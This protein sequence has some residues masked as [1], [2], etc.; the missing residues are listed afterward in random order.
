VRDTYHY[1]PQ[2]LLDAPDCPPLALHVWGYFL[3]LNQT[4]GSSGF[5]PS[6]LTRQD[7]Q[8]WEIDEGVSLDRWE[9]NAIMKLDATYIAHCIADQK[10]ET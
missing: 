9:R 5:G 6:R 8:A 1:T 10:R 7:I 4:R 2:Q 3:D